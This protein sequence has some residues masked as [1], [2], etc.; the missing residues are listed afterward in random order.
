MTFYSTPGLMRISYFSEL[1]KTSWASPDDKL[2]V[3]ICFT[4]NHWF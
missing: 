4:G 2:E 1:L 3:A